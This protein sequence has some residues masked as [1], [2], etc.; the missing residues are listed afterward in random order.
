MTVSKRT[1]FEILRRDGH[2]CHYCGAKAPGVAL[3]VDHVLPVTL[4][5]TD[6]PANLV[7]ACA[8]CNAGKSSMPPDAAILPE[9]DE[10]AIAWQAARHVA[11][12]RIAEKREA[13]DASLEK[14]RSAWMSWDEDGAF[15]PI[16]WRSKVGGWLADGLTPADIDEALDIALG[17]RASSRN[18][19]RYMAGV[20]Q[21]MLSELDAETRRV[22]GEE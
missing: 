3:T 17:S 2:A 22:L 9:V 6:D 7:T 15:L 5:G 11:M 19:F 10:K 21:R 14:F 18:V 16:D 1:R 12:Q 8:D 20:A 13:R 4:G